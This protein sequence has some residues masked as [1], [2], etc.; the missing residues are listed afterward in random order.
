VIVNA[1]G[2][3]VNDVIARCGRTKQ[4][5]IET[6][7]GTHIVL[8]KPISDTCF[9]L[10]A[11]D[12]RAVFVLPWHGKTLVGTTETPFAG[13]PED[14][15][16]L[17]S[18]IEYL[19]TTVQRYF[20]TADTRIADSFSGLRVLPASTTKAFAR[21][22]DTQYLDDDGL[23]TIYGGKLTAY[24]A[25]AETVMRYVKKHTRTTKAIANTRHLPLDLPP[26]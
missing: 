19:L 12:G 26:E 24:R 7:Q 18:E 4:L 5:T 22:R 25:T 13:K 10:E 1:S 3:W 6:I 17:A 14:T 23:I 21:S 20:P 11:Q 9:Y 15:T 16:P 2:A 8:E